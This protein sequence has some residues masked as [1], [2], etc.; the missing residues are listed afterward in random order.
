MC[1]EN[2]NRFSR[3]TFT[4]RKKLSENLFLFSKLRLSLFCNAV[5]QD[6][7]CNLN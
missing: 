6:W 3:I 1:I 7:Q 2:T 4:V 5:K